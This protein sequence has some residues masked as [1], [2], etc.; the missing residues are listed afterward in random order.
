V[1]AELVEQEAGDR[2]VADKAKQYLNFGNT[3]AN[4]I[5]TIKQFWNSS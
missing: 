5:N 4:M 2:T 3:P 1:W